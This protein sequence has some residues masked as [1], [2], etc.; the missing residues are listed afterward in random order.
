M[1]YRD[2]LGERRWEGP[3][4]LLTWGRG[5]AC[6][7]V[8]IGPLWLPAKRV[9]PYHGRWTPPTLVDNSDQLD[10][11]CQGPDQPAVPDVQDRALMP[12]LSPSLESGK[13]ATG[14]TPPP[15]PKGI[16]WGESKTFNSRAKEVMKDVGFTDKQISGCQLMLPVN[17]KIREAWTPSTVL[18]LK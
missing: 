7:S 18:S 9:K 3:V 1:L 12:D 10:L 8:P 16:T 17:G 11:A 5:Y 4:E 6:I 13:Q 14:T 15:E 2:P